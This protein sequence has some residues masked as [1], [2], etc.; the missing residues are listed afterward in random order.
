MQ[1]SKF[2]PQ[3]FTKFSCKLPRITISRRIN[4]ERCFA[5]KIHD[6]YFWK[7]SLIKSDERDAHKSLRSLKKERA[8]RVGNKKRFLEV[9]DFI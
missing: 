6:S 5:R 3:N 4:H 1:I 7:D 2:L 8:E 9:D